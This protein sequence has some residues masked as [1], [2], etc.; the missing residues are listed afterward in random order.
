MTDAFILSQVDYYARHLRC[1]HPRDWNMIVGLLR[2]S[3]GHILL[4]DAQLVG[5][6]LG[7]PVKALGLVLFPGVV[8]GW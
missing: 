6:Q 1:G 2:P 8:S 5:E 4:R 7:Q 3:R